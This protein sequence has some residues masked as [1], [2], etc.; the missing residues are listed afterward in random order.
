[1]F[2]KFQTIHFSQEFEQVKFHFMEKNN[3]YK[4]M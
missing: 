4:L 1:M 3:R 2:I